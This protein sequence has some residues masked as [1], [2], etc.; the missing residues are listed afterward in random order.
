MARLMGFRAPVL[1]LLLV[2]SIL[3]AS[4][5]SMSGRRLSQDRLPGEEGLTDSEVAAKR[6][7]ENF[8]QR[9]ALNRIEAA[10]KDNA[11]AEEAEAEA[12]A[13]VKVDEEKE[14][15]GAKVEE[16]DVGAEEGAVAQEG[17]DGS[18]TS[19]RIRGSQVLFNAENEDK[20]VPRCN[21][22]LNPES[23]YLAQVGVFA[24][25]P[26]DRVTRFVP[27]QYEVMPYVEMRTT[28]PFVREAQVAVRGLGIDTNAIVGSRTNPVRRVCGNWAWTDSGVY[29][30]QV[31]AA[32]DAEVR[33]GYYY[34][35][36]GNNGAAA[37]VLGAYL[38][39]EIDVRGR[40]GLI[41]SGN[42]NIMNSNSNSDM[43]GR[44]GHYQ[45]EFDNRAAGEVNKITNTQVLGPVNY[46][47]G[48]G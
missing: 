3:A 13:E 36:H 34:R 1:A 37:G 20:W 22:T 7:L 12:E 38:D 40:S 18:D 42:R 26:A 33:L 25:Q 6:W 19:G 39:Q 47:L 29:S 41:S 21:A 9:S 46:R 5:P 43:Q 8:V 28:A 27:T 10:A 15:A 23:V 16:G 17:E 14:V 30:W 44:A 11:A 24:N 35:Q 31:Y 48:R 32:A 4:T 45:A 2:L